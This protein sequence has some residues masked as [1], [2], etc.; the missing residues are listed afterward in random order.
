MQGYANLIG[1]A[2][3]R[4]RLSEQEHDLCEVLQARLSNKLYRL[5]KEQH[6]RELAESKLRQSQKMEALGQLTG[7]IAHDF[8]NFLAT[9]SSSL[10]LLR[11]RVSTN[12]TDSIARYIDLAEGATKRA[13][14]LTHRLLSFARQQPLK[15]ELISP[16]SIIE[17]LRD[18]L[19]S[20][21][22]T[23]I[24]LIFDLETGDYILCDLNQ[25]E[26]AVMNLCINARDAMPEGGVLT[27]SVRQTLI[28]KDLSAPFN[29][30]AGTYVAVVVS[31]N[32]VGMPPDVARRAFDPFFTTKQ[33]NSGTGLGLSMVYGFCLQ[34][35]GYVDVSSQEG[36]GTQVT[37]YFPSEE[38]A[39]T[40][41]PVA[42]PS[43]NYPRGK[44]EVI[45]LV[46]DELGVR[47][48]AAELLADLGYIVMQATNADAALKKSELMSRLDLLVTGVGLAGGIDGVELAKR[49]KKARPDIKV[50]FTTGYSQRYEKELNELGTL[51][52]KPFTLAD[53]AKQIRSLL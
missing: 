49:L 25:L 24:D 47:Q 16:A 38:R 39:D 40:S 53:I 34:S 26:N 18:L 22:G 43:E 29:L 51:C 14:S 46:D 12:R 19:R 45:L 11:L 1:A 32:G 6:E 48:M 44:G 3:V 28:Q 31:D 4:L 5:K 27:I 20:V 30:P 23:G 42:K 9:I 50:L 52:L 10:E 15:P 7:G 8:N 36:V 35:N 21:L 41:A 37:M 13:A 33:P 17:S 2:I